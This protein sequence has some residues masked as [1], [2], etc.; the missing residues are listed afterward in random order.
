MV[1]V[2]RETQTG[3]LPGNTSVQRRRFD[4]LLRSQWPKTLRAPCSEAAA[5]GIQNRRPVVASHPWRP[6][7]H[8]TAAG[9]QPASA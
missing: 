3:Q 9:R 8:Y 6:L 5:M 1:C 2:S 7:P 4:S